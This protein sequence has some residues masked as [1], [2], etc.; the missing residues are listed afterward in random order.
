MTD[1]TSDLLILASNAS[2]TSD[3]RPFQF[4]KPVAQG[5]GY[6]VA[7]QTPPAGL[8]CTVAG[9][10]SGTVGAG[11]VTSVRVLCGYPVQGAFDLT[12]IAGVTGQAAST[13]LSLTDAVAWAPDGYAGGAAH[14]ITPG[15]TTFTLGEPVPRGGTCALSVTAQPAGPA[16]LCAVLPSGGCTGGVATAPIAAQV[17]CVQQV[18]LLALSGA[19]GQVSSVAVDGQG[20]ALA[21]GSFTGT[22]NL[23]HGARTGSTFS[24]TGSG[25]VVSG[26]PAGRT[27]AAASPLSASW[28]R[29]FPAPGA[30]PANAGAA[31]VR[32]LAAL[33]GGDVIAGGGYTGSVDLGDGSGPSPVATSESMFLAR[34]SAGGS[35]LWARRFGPGVITSLAASPAQIV[36]GGVYGAAA[37]GQETFGGAP[38]GLTASGPHRDFIAAFD[39]SAGA[40]NFSL[41]AGGGADPAGASLRLGPAVALD[42]V[43]DVVAVGSSSDATAPSASS[44]P[45][46]ATWDSSGK[47]PCVAGGVGNELLFV[48]NAATS[49][50]SGV[51][52]GVAVGAADVL[53]VSGQC[54]G[55]APKVKGTTLACGTAGTAAFVAKYSART[56]CVAGSSGAPAQLQG[57]S[58]GR[59]LTLLATGGTSKAL[60]ISTDAAGNVLLAGLYSGTPT[61]A[62]VALFAGSATESQNAFATR[63][64]AALA[65]PV[66]QAV[67]ATGPLQI[68]DVS[69]GALGSIWVSGSWSGTLTYRGRTPALG[70]TAAVGEPMLLHFP[71]GPP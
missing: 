63:L 22:V 60:A 42:S 65:A 52:S 18:E 4:P 10:G 26:D 44:G 50:S 28:D 34:V 62:G 25:F 36:A 21:S 55:S 23:G 49:T 8:V 17:R 33:A 15:A 29:L 41:D 31:R 11:D 32:A 9:G 14:V 53:F 66:H 39:A 1:N 6:Q 43:G 45:W 35:V 54:Q 24:S 67:N 57:P 12:T 48:P 51:V 58:A 70:T 61:L 46:L 68:T 2:S 56:A 16:Q 64:T 71:Q 40:C 19:V 5:Q 37:G 13:G 3:A 20:D 7:V 69:P 27:G 59:P 38:C 47:S 30:S